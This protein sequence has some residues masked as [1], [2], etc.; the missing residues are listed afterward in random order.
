VGMQIGI[1]RRNNLTLQ[2]TVGDINLASVVRLKN[3][4]ISVAQK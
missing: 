2:G 3:H 1:S 4:I